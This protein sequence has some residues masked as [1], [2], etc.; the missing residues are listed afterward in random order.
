[1]KNTSLTQSVVPRFIVQVHKKAFRSHGLRVFLLIGC[2]TLSGCGSEKI[3]VG[4]F[5]GESDAGTRKRG[6]G[7]PA[8]GRPPGKPRTAHER[9]EEELRRIARQASTS[10]PYLGTARKDSLLG[11]LQGTPRRQPVQQA[12][13]LNG[14]G[15][16]NLK[17]GDNRSAQEQFREADQLLS[18]FLKLANGSQ[19]RQ[20]EQLQYFVT[21]H[22]VLGWLRVAEQ[23]NCVDCDQSE[24]CLYPISTAGVHQDP[25]AAREALSLLDQLRAWRPDD[26]RTRWLQ[27]LLGQLS[28]ESGVSPKAVRAGNPGLEAEA[29]CSPPVE[30]L[31]S[32]GVEIPGET[33][34][35]FRNI[36]AAKGVDS[37]DLSGGL[38]V[39]G[40]IRRA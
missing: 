21:Y 28:G 25:A 6:E 38:A 35:R 33:I 15:V 3:R 22:R 5:T 39:E 12:M 20:A 4:E 31:G 2:L 18:D 9:M 8:A 16:E 13:L 14:L 1:M 10:N 30:R 32:R 11:E 19:R 40:D 23:T 7:G 26:L 36:A 27:H 34:S 37:L 24:S 29:D 17:L